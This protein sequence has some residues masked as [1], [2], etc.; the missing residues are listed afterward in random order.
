MTEAIY[1]ISTSF[2]S[3]EVVNV[4][5]NTWAIYYCNWTERK[6]LFSV[7]NIRPVQL[8]FPFMADIISIFKI[9]Q[10]NPIFKYS[11]QIYRYVDQLTKNLKTALLEME[12]YPISS[13]NMLKYFLFGGER[14]LQLSKT[15]PVLAI[16]V[17]GRESHCLCPLE[18]EKRIQT[19][20]GKQGQL[21]LAH[22]GFHKSRNFYNIL[23]K[24]GKNS[25]ELLE[26]YKINNLV[27]A[28]RMGFEF[29]YN[30]SPYKKAFKVLCHVSHL[31]NTTIK[32][33]FNKVL[34]EVLEY[35]FF[36]DFSKLKC[37]REK[38]K[39][40]SQLKEIEKILREHDYID[41]RKLPKVKNLGDVNKLYSIVISLECEEI[42]FHEY[43]K[44]VF[45]CPPK[46]K[47]SIFLDE[48]E[49]GI[50]PITSGGALWKEGRNMHHCIASYAED[51]ALKDNEIY[52]Y[53]VSYPGEKPAS[54]L[55]KKNNCGEWEI[56][57]LLGIT[58]QPVGFG[59]TAMVEKW[60]ENKMNHLHNYQTDFTYAKT[61]A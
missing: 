48:K 22:Y 14:A 24:F 4:R 35:G 19:I 37:D 55:I 50:F 43:E 61:Q 56:E 17:A 9:N 29:P 53:H 20:L 58:N 51:I 57:E 27:A 18:Y 15:C 36:N 42:Q 3:L 7:L 21:I 25:I 23:R 32:L 33:L 46:E 11:H 13:N 16:L 1:N 52:A 2:G 30:K 6:V 44:I 54:L 47:F 5:M 38:I 26:L 28:S 12:S 39:L 60:I 31:S 34:S 10:L 40:S 45:R 41:V 49:Y 8:Y 59:T